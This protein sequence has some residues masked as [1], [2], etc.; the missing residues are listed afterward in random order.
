MKWSWTGAKALPT[1]TAGTAG[2]AGSLSSQPA[3]SCTSMRA[4]LSTGL[5]AAWR[6]QL[7]LPF[8]WWKQGVS[9]MAPGI[10]PRRQRVPPRA[11]CP[12]RVEWELW[13]TAQ[14]ACG[15]ACDSTRAFLTSFK[16]TAQSLEQ[17]RSAGSRLPVELPRLALALALRAESKVLACIAGLDM[18]EAGPPPPRSPA[19]CVSCTARSAK[20]PSSLP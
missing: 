12:A 6:V 20:P 7:P 2:T 18:R 19:R 14:D 4:P 8:V 9:L 17:V 13:F 16:G 11:S 15:H 3:V 1:P 10:P 5:A